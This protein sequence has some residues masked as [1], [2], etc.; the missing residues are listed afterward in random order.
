MR[1]GYPWT[2]GK[3][4]AVRARTNSQRDTKNFSGRGRYTPQPGQGPYSWK[5]GGGPNIDGYDNA[6]AEQTGW[7]VC[8]ISSHLEAI[9]FIYGV[10]A[11][12]RHILQ[13]IFKDG[14]QCEYY[15]DGGRGFRLET[16]YFMMEQ[17]AKPGE[18]IWSHLILEEFPYTSTS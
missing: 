3:V 12:D 18:I 1:V 7:H 11:T 5:L 8:P 10:E 14:G 9:R 4:Q 2:Q 16:I 13:V 6:T 17:A 15:G